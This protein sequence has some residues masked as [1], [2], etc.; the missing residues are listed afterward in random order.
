M[1]A[2]WRPSAR[3]EALTKAQATEIR[4]RLGVTVDVED[5]EPEA[6][7]AIESFEDMELKRDILAD[8]KFREYDKP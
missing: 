2:A 8:V 4:E 1:F 5:G 6:P 3:A 7:S